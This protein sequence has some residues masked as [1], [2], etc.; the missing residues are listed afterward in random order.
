MW[1]RAPVEENNVPSAICQE[2]FQ[3]RVDGVLLEQRDMTCQGALQ[4]CSC[5]HGRRGCC[6]PPCGRCSRRLQGERLVWYRHLTS[7]RHAAE[8]FAKAAS[9]LFIM[10]C[11]QV[12]RP[13]ASLHRYRASTRLWCKGYRMAT[14]RRV[15]VKPLVPNMSTFSTVTLYVH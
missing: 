5:W 6:L 9:E 7:Q 2:H 8:L 12:W 1:N 15:P 3:H 10:V 14:R 11:R 13:S 4:L